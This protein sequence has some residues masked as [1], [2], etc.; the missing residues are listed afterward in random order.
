MEQVASVVSRIRRV[1]VAE[2]RGSEL[3]K[4][5]KEDLDEGMKI[6]SRRQ[7]M[8]NF[9]DRLEAGWAVVEYED[10]ALASNSEDEKRMEKAVREAD[11]KVAKKH[12][13]RDSKEAARKEAAWHELPPAFATTKPPFAPKITAGM[14]PKPLG[15][16][17]HCGLLGH[18]RRKCPKALTSVPYPLISVNEHGA[19]ESTCCGC[20]EVGNVSPNGVETV[21][22]ITPS[23]G[24]CGDV[25]GCGRCWEV[26]DGDTGTMSVRGRLSSCVT[27]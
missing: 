16:C 25:E 4:K 8:S 20:S 21:G 2:E 11:R 22:E 7:K 3:L 24:T 14:V 23:F 5:V 6:L 26:Q 12:K 17:F 19:G 9:A 18:F 10:D 15:T 13:L 27:F 1:G